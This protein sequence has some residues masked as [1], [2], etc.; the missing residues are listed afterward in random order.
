MDEVEKPLFSRGSCAID[1]GDSVILTGGFEGWKTKDG[2]VDGRVSR[3]DLTGFVEELPQMMIGRAEHAC[4]R[5]NEGSQK[6][7]AVAGG[8]PLTST[9]EVL[10]ADTQAW[11]YLSPLPVAVKFT[12]GLALHNIFYVLGQIILYPSYCNNLNLNHF[13]RRS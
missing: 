2:I 10:L 11:T 9:A 1:D 3:Y 5:Y 12:S 7:Y 4:A 13:A 8:F 6:V